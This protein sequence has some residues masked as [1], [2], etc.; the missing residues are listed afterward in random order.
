MATDDWR[1]ALA[2]CTGSDYKGIKELAE[3]QQKVSRTLAES[4]QKISR[5]PVNY[6]PTA[7][8]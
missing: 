7:D 4:Q 8:E 6:C 5:K 1:I 3:S 2:Q